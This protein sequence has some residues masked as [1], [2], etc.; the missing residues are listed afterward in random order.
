MKIS[1]KL[2][3][4]S[5]VLTIGCT[6]EKTSVTASA[7]QESQM[8]AAA[9]TPEELGRL[10]AQI[11]KRPAEA[12]RLLSEKGHTAESFETAVRDVTEN[13]EAS[14]RYAAAFRDEER[15]H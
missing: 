7:T 15:A 5:A 12:T 9:S 2:L 6:E 13:Q 8:A 10:G 1:M 4:L 3:L 14:R 11:R